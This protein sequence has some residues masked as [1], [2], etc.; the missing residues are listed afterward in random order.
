MIATTASTRVLTRTFRVL[1]VLETLAFLC[2]ALLHLG[3]RNAELA[4]VELVRLGFHG[5]WN[6]TLH[7]AA[8]QPP[9]TARS[10]STT[11]EAWM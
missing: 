6:Y 4:A 1:I 11:P 7:P 10:S 9:L 2:F 8:A 5:E 3:V